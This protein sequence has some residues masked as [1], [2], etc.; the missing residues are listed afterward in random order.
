MRT[1]EFKG[2]LP[3]IASHFLTKPFQTIN[4]SVI[5][6]YVMLHLIY[7]AYHTG[8]I[9]KKCPAIYIMASKKRGTL[10]TGV[11]SNLIKRVYQHRN[12]LT[13]GFTQR[14]GCK[15]LVYYELHEDMINAIAREKQ[16]KGGSR[17]K[18]IVLIES[19]NKDWL[20]LYSRLL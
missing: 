17:K 15:Y 6:S 16:L 3:V 18:K 5:P 13:P 20:D 8:I 2:F 14:Y 11:T 9:M 7:L 10:Y 1:R 19:M 4:A 12:N